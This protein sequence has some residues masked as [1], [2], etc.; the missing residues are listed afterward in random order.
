[1][2]RIS[3]IG[4]IGNELDAV[5]V[6]T[7]Q[8]APGALAAMCAKAGALHAGDTVTIISYQCEEQK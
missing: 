2:L 3:F 4:A 6:E 1:M 7:P 5:V 8:D